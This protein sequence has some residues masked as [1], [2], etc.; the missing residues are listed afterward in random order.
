MNEFVIMKKIK[1]VPSVRNK[2]IVINEEIVL[3][4]VQFN[5]IITRTFTATIL[6]I[7]RYNL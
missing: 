4:F 3:I 1:N 5:K 7:F 6:P 2:D